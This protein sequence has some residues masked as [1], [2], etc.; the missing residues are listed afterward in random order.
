MARR[1]PAPSPSTDIP[2]AVP[3]PADAVEQPTAAA[4]EPTG[5]EFPFGAL[6]PAQ[7]EP[8]VTE[9]LTAAE[10]NPTTAD[11]KP[12]SRPHVRSWTRDYALGYQILTDD[13]L[14]VIVVRFDQKPAD[15]VLEMVK[16]KGF[17]YRELR[18]H[19]RVWVTKN[20]WEGRTL[21]DQLDQ[22]LYRYRTGQTRPDQGV[23]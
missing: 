9:T 19:G 3:T 17:K 21:T 5:V 13:L 16:A 4:A 14:K 15:E 7:T 8:T 12:G 18:E 22:E 23:A 11:G 1:K 2:Q 6:A 10:S 20:D